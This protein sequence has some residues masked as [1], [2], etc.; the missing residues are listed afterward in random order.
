MRSVRGNHWP[1]AS[2]RVH[3]SSNRRNVHDA[4]HSTDPTEQSSPGSDTAATG[5]PLALF[6]RPA[7]LRQSPDPGHA[8]YRRSRSR[9]LRSFVRL[10]AAD[11]VQPTVPAMSLHG[12][13]RTRGHCFAPRAILSVRGARWRRR[14]GRPE[15]RAQP[16]AALQRQ[17]VRPGAGP[18]RRRSTT[19]SGAGRSDLAH[20]CRLSE[21]SHTWADYPN[22]GPGCRTAQHTSD[23]CAYAPLPIPHSETE[24][25]VT[26]GLEASGDT[27]YRVTSQIRDTPPA[28]LSRLS[29]MDI[30][31]GHASAVP[32][33]TPALVSIPRSTPL[34]TCSHSVEMERYV[35]PM[36]LPPLR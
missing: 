17:W 12:D 29:P 13:S 22:Q 15:L 23:K 1:R 36:C 8:S 32:F 33:R 21:N 31:E 6:R 19:T 9:D 25:A 3:S 10:R 18:D 24:P 7:R 16:L 27:P 26:P 35:A 5:R 34:L 20:P 4:A 2:P 30:H 14:I 28:S 11:R